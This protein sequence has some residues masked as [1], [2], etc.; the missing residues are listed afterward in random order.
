MLIE[1]YRFQYDSWHVGDDEA[2]EDHGQHQHEQ[3]LHLPLISGGHAHPGVRLVD[4]PELQ[5]HRNIRSYQSNNRESKSNHI[6]NGFRIATLQVD[7]K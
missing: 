1:K 5:V 7:D 6:E 2:D 4:L 3:V